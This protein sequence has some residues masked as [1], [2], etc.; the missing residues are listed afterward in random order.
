MVSVEALLVDQH[1]RSHRYGGGTVFGKKRSCCE[2]VRLFPGDAGQ[3]GI[4]TDIALPLKCQHRRH[5]RLAPSMFSALTVA[6]IDVATT[7][8]GIAPAGIVR[9]K[10]CQACTGR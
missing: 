3:A 9:A 4:T 10:G 1:A 7:S 6:R 8:F 5:A 2:T